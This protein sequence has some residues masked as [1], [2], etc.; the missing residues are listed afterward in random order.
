[1]PDE[2]RYDDQLIPGLHE[3]RQIIAAIRVSKEEILAASHNQFQELKSLFKHELERII[4]ELERIKTPVRLTLIVSG[5]SILIPGL[6]N[7]QGEDMSYT[8]PRDH[9]D[10]PFSLAPITAA[11][12]EG[13]VDVVFTERVESSNVDVV[14]IVGDAPSQSFHFGTFGGATVNRI[15]TFNGADFIVA[16]LV[17]NVT[18]G[19]VTFSGGGI[20]VA[21]LTPDPAPVS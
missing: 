7:F 17:F 15:V 11:D 14:S 12:S 21:G 19:A 5:Q 18:P 9:Q 16:S 8:V 4:A 1:M 13:P 20:D 10:E 2:K 3:S 6:R